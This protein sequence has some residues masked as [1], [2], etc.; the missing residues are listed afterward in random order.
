MNMQV[1]KTPGV[2]YFLKSIRGHT[3]N[4]AIVFTGEQ[5]SP[6]VPPK[7][8]KVIAHCSAMNA[9]AGLCSGILWHRC[10]ESAGHSSLVKCGKCLLDFYYCMSVYF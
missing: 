3:P 5:P 2:Y 10:T 6:P 8:S 7:P 1:I 9:Q 4:Y